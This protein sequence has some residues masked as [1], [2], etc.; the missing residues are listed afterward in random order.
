MEWMIQWRDCARAIFLVH[1]P[2]TP[3][4]FRHCSWGTQ[5]FPKTFLGQPPDVREPQEHQ[6]FRL[7]FSGPGQ[8]LIAQPRGFAS[9]CCCAI[10]FK[11]RQYV[12]FPC[13][14]LSTLHLLISYSSSFCITCFATENAFFPLGNTQGVLQKFP[15]N[16]VKNMSFSS[17]RSFLKSTHSQGICGKDVWWN[18]YAW[19]ATLFCTLVSLS[20]E[21]LIHKPIE[22]SW[23]SEYHRTQDP[24]D[25]HR[26][27]LPVLPPDPS[28]QTPGSH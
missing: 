14:L 18:I 4:V 21:P 25:N 22:V 23:Y 19:I 13:G 8:G 9:L 15:G 2:R 3:P 24:G 1:L 11:T 7:L 27:P 6:D 26:M 16:G 5:P 12:L 17:D 20:F 10:R 28:L